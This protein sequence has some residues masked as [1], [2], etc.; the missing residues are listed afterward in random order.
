MMELTQRKL[1]ELLDYNPDTGVFTWLDNTRKGIRH[2]RVAG[3]QSHGYITI[4][5]DGKHY[6]AH[7]LAWLYVYGQWPVNMIDHINRVKSDNR[8]ANLREATNEENQR[9]VE[10]G[11]KNKSGFKGVFWEP[12]RQKWKAR[13]QMNKKKYT[14][15][16]FDRIE[17]AVAAYESFCQKHYGEFYVPQN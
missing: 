9:N 12:S 13:T 16:R 6:R 15:G 3:S 10:V 8:I 5:I 2:D 11:K 7:R 17:D 4:A 14:L 1:K